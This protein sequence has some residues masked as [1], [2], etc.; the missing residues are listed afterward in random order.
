MIRLHTTESMTRENLISGLVALVM[1]LAWGVL[2]FVISE[3]R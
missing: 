3:A 2:L 1:V